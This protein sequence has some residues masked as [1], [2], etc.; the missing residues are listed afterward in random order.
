MAERPKAAVLKT[1]GHAS[2]PWVRILLPPPYCLNHFGL[3]T[4]FLLVLDTA[5]NHR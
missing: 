2:A 5:V 1:V 3:A 4:R